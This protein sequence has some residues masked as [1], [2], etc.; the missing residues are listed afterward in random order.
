MLQTEKYSKRRMVCQWAGDAYDLAALPS[1]VFST[2]STILM[3][4]QWTCRKTCYSSAGYAF[5][6]FATRSSRSAAISFLND[7]SSL[8]KRF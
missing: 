5:I 8:T 3:H 6:G 1:R 4:I 7:C 2:G